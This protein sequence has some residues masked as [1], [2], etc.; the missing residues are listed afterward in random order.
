MPSQA[1]PSQAMQDRPAGKPNQAMPCQAMPSH[2]KPGRRFLVKVRWKIYTNKAVNESTSTTRPMAGELEKAIKSRFKAVMERVAKDRD[3]S[4]GGRTTLLKV[5]GLRSQEGKLL[6]PRSQD[7]AGKSWEF[8]L[9]LPCLVSCSKSRS[10]SRRVIRMS[11]KAT[12][13]S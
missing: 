8:L 10:G 11:L 4:R 7:P 1:M 9:A 2:A 13:R 12:T 6:D 5:F 3:W